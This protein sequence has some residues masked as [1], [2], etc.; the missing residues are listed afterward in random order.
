MRWAVGDGG[1]ARCDGN[2]IGNIGGAVGQN[3]TSEKSS[4]N[5]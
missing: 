1:S 2:N 3:G 4:D 5:G